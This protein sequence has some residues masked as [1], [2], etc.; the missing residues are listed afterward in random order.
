M[1]R[2]DWIQLIIA[3]LAMVATL[4]GRTQGLGLVTEPLLAD[5]H[6]E[7]VTYASFN[8]WATL[9]GAILCIPCGRLID[10]Y[11]GRIVAA[12]ILAALGATVVAMSHITSQPATFVAI[13]LTRAFGQSA[14]SVVSLALV[15]KWF[16][17]QLPKA[18]GI[19]SLM[20]GIGFVACFPT[21][22]SLVLSIG[23]RATW[24]GVGVAVLAI[25]VIAWSLIR[26]P[27]VTA[28][29]AEGSTESGLRDLSFE[30]ALLHPAFWIFAVSSSIYGLVASGISLFNESILQLHGF[31]PTVFH[32]SLV[33]VTL[34][35]LA[36]NFAAGWLATKYSIRR[37]MGTGM[38]IL[39]LSL[40]ALPNVRTFAHVAAYAVAMGAAGGVV[41]VVFF[42]VWGQVFGKV[43]LGRIQ[44]GAQMMTVLASAVGPLILAETLRRTGSYDGMF[45][46]LG[47][48]VGALG[49]ACWLVPL[50]S[51]Q[52]IAEPVTS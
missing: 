27:A 50:P 45:Y 10:R 40:W 12:T 3:A 6:L 38:L 18:M 42:T 51:R 33:I 29:A 43:H 20:V 36:T 34:V 28:P 7:R 8:L 4:P 26:N 52:L 25:A 46:A 15:G 14:L 47:I 13:T 37:I 35:G 17:S 32:K 31:D 19:Y 16:S 21:V 30:E 49:I 9:I 48:L 22:G 2:D 1:K 5:L 24:Q 39:M 44:G 41:T 23:W 11:G